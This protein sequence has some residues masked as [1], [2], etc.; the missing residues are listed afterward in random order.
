[1]NNHCG[2]SDPPLQHKSEGAGKGDPFPDPRC[3]SGRAL[4]VKIVKWGKWVR[5]VGI[6]GIDGE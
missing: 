2:T 3:P 6:E 1:M 5:G 4:D